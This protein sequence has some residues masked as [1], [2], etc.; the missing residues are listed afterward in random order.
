M[1][2]IKSIYIIQTILSY[3]N[4]IIKFKLFTYSKKYQK[5]LNIGL[6][7]YQKKFFDKI[8][9]NS[10]NNY[11][12]YLCAPKYEYNYWPPDDISYNKNEKNELLKKDLLKYNININDFKNYV[13]NYF[14]KYKEKFIK[15]LNEEYLIKKNEIDKGEYTHDGFRDNEEII[16][17]KEFSDGI[18][19]EIDINSPL[20]DI[21]YKSKLFG[22]LFVIP[23][24]FQ[25]I[26]RHKLKE[27]Y[28]TVFKN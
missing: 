4:D 12:K 8:R 16:G 14:V 17:F 22:E 27:D 24:D 9:M 7:D 28:I 3:T 15:E 21:F 18:K 19:L 11:F 25:F 26:E 2:K 10:F 5:L 23:I 6:I 13:K 1:E 20:F